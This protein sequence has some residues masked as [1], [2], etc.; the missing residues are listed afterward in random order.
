[1]ISRQG[2]RRR[3]GGGGDEA[4]AEERARSRKAPENDSVTFRIHLR[5][6]ISASRKIHGAAGGRRKGLLSVTYIYPAINFAALHNTR[7]RAHTAAR[8]VSTEYRR[9]CV[10]VT[11]FLSRS[12][13]VKQKCLVNFFFFDTL[14]SAQYFYRARTTS[15]TSRRSIYIHR[16]H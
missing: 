16:Q 7:T 13:I 5:V 12:L 15:V 10:R 1:M 8:S 4:K 2:R 9:T 6:I 14:D 11:H 3:G